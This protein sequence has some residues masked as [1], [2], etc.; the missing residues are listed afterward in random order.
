MSNQDFIRVLWGDDRY[1][2]GRWSKVFR[3]DVLKS[4]K[5]G[6]DQSP[7][8]VWCYGKN[9][10][11]ELTRLGVAVELVNQEPFPGLADNIKIVPDGHRMRRPWR[12]KHELIAAAT[13]GGRE[14]IYCDWDVRNQC[15]QEEAFKALEGRDLT[16]TT[17]FYGRSSRNWGDPTRT[18]SRSR[19]IS[20]SG[21]WIHC[22][23]DGFPK[24][25]VEIMRNAG[26]PNAEFVDW[27]DEFSMTRFICQKN[28]GRWTTE[29][30]WLEQYESPIMMQK[31]KKCPW[32]DRETLPIEFTW[33]PLFAQGGRKRIVAKETPRAARRRRQ[34]RRRQRPAVL[35][36]Q[37]RAAGFGGSANTQR[38]H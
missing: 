36:V 16:L 24:A 7:F 8:T 35:L 19:Q 34:H 1:P 22:K 38:I 2:G 26:S 5:N 23:G 3:D 6:R 30:E 21:N 14:V 4:I 31:G 32:H 12:F 33:T 17:F 15:T 28:G 20:V 10:A 27:H 11:D 25:I 37:V 18:T 13:T 9:N 29:R